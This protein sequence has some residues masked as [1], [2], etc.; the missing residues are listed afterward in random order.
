MITPS[1]L[2]GLA[3]VITPRVLFLILIVLIALSKF[4]LTKNRY[5]LPL[6][7]S[8]II[9]IYYLAFS[10]LIFKITQNE[11]IESDS[12]Y[13]LKYLGFIL[14]F[15]IGVWLIGI[16]RFFPSIVELKNLFMISI[17]LIIGFV[18]SASSFAT[19]GPILGVIL[20]GKS[21]E[22]G[23]VGLL[24]PLIAFSLGLSI[25]VGL[26]V[27]FSTRT[28]NRISKRNWWSILQ[29]MTGILLIVNMAY[30]WYTL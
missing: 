26:L 12:I 20:V 11:L 21:Q 13:P 25:P 27:A 3:A 1:F 8:S 16:E 29:I 7:L 2:A 15:L 24:S 5:F 18:F 28:I 10:I 17:L 6:C 22:S 4:D 23:M 30:S 14:N 19:T 9:V